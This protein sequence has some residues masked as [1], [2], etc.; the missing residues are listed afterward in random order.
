MDLNRLIFIGSAA[1]VITACTQKSDN[2]LLD[3]TEGQF[4]QSANWFFECLADYDKS[5]A[6]FANSTVK[7]DKDREMKVCLEGTQKRTASAG[8]TDN[9][10]FEQIQDSRVRDRYLALKSEPTR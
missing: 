1:F 3:A 5:A 8:I 4:K 9:V 2:P 10:S 7:R 6:T